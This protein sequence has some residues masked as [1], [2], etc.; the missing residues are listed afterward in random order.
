MEREAIEGE[1]DRG[2]NCSVCYCSS[3]HTS[4]FLG[5]RHCS[6]LQRAE[7]KL[8]MKMCCLLQLIFSRS[9]T[10]VARLIFTDASKLFILLWSV[11][12]T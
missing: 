12:C 4:H 11:S 9:A 8:S 2:I 7:A 5:Q 1:K 10:A 6:I 3:R